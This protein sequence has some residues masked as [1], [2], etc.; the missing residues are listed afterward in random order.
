MQFA[1]HVGPREVLAAGI[2]LLGAED[3]EVSFN[4]D[5]M[6]FV[7]QLVPEPTPMAV[8][9]T[10]EHMKLMRIYLRGHLPLL[11]TTWKL[12]GIAQANGRMIDLDVMVY[13]QMETADCARQVSFCFTA[14]PVASQLA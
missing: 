5:G 12:N 13:S 9:F 7:L 4:L 10:R 14:H 2:V 11:S 1:V 3:R 8:E 6:V